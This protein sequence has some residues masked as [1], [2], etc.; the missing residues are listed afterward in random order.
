MIMRSWLALCQSE[1][2]LWE[3]GVKMK[4][5]ERELMMMVAQVHLSCKAKAEKEERVIKT[6]K[7][8]C[9]FAY[10]RGENGLQLAQGERWEA[11]PLMCSKQRGRDLEGETLR[12]SWQRGSGPRK[13]RPTAGSW[14]E[15]TQQSSS[16]VS[17]KT[18]FGV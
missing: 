2:A 10:D 12:I 9:L 6:F 5:S 16:K 18:R 1:A 15:K 3:M 13:R 4:A 7:E 17:S 11:L 8:A 14:T